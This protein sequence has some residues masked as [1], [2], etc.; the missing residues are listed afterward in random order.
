MDSIKGGDDYAVTTQT[1]PQTSVTAGN[2]FGS[3]FF[4]DPRARTKQL[5]LIVAGLLA[6][7]VLVLVLRRK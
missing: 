1:G 3:G 7:G 4:P 5:A 2:F 6:A